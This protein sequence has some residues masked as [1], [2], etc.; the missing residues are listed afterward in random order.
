MKKIAWILTGILLPG[1]YLL[2]GC[3]QEGLDT[4]DTSRNEIYFGMENRNK[5][6][7]NVFVDT[8]VF[9]FGEF[10]NTPDTV[11][12]I[13]V[14][15]LGGISAADRTFEYEVVDSLT[16]AQEGTFY[17]LSETT[18]VIPADSTH[19]Y[20]PVQ[21]YNK[22]DMKKKPMYYLTLQ[23]RE[24]ENF[25]LG[26]QQE[27]VDK[28]NDKYVQLTRHYVGMSV[29]VQK[30]ANWYKVE[31]YFLTFSEEKYKLINELCHLTREDWDNVRFYVFEVYWITVKNYLQ[32]QINK[33]NPV[34][35][36]D[37]RT[38]RK[39]PM[40]VNGLTGI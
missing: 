17:A 36:E 16:T 26:L 34:M 21:I 24:N 10:P 14:N 9:S 39:T 18:G 8:T 22:V 32:D 2:G 37:M 1:V 30:P 27:Y 33:G 3:S 11:I 28:L 23:L 25:S 20:I 6:Q 15:A 12:Y 29:R 19:G 38:G 4:Y 5:S 35:E 7:A 31:N 40:K 13:R